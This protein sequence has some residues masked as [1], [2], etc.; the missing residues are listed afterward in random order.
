MFVVIVLVSP[1]YAIWN[2]GYRQGTTGS[3]LGKAAMKFKAIGERNWQPIGFGFS[4]VRGLAHTA[5]LLV[6]GLGSLWPLWDANRQ[7]LADKIVG[8]VCVSIR[9][10]AVGY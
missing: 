3:S 8:T 2:F 7:T 9:P 4:I 5:D 10:Q 1:I 6:C